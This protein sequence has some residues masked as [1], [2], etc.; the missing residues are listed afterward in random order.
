M[1]L[2]I[3]PYSK[4]TSLCPILGKTHA[5]MFN[6]SCPSSLDRPEGKKLKISFIGI[7]PY[8]IY[9]PVGGSDFDFIRILAQK[10]KFTPKFIPEKS[11]D[12]VKVNGTTYGMFHR[13]RYTWLLSSLTHTTTSFHLS[14]YQTKKVRWALGNQVFHIIETNWLTFCQT[15]T[16]MNL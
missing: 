2:C 15:C 14:R 5:E 16:S 8:I 7:S 10:Y 4:T 12:P 9:D 6:D 13:V 11:Y 3:G 1:F